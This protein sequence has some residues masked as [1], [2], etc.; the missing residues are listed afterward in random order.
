MQIIVAWFIFPPCDLA[1]ELTR[2][3]HS[4]CCVVVVQTSPFA[5]VCLDNECCVV[6]VVQQ[7]HLLSCARRNP[8]PPITLFE[9]KSTH[10]VF[11]SSFNCFCR[12]L[13]EFH[14]HIYP[15]SN[16]LI[17]ICPSSIL[18]HKKERRYQHLHSSLSINH[19]S[20]QFH[21]LWSLFCLTYYFC[22]LKSLRRH[23]KL[24][25]MMMAVSHLFNEICN[26][27]KLLSDDDLMHQKITIL[28][29]SRW[30]MVDGCKRKTRR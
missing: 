14:C 12:P 26:I 2:C 4:M 25:I 30:T 20:E 6:V 21:L 24:M 9:T 22:I 3:W 10:C 17:V 27:R 29:K 28:M 5:F 16:K 11:V 18:H 19:P 15:S 8:P 1:S 13:K 23:D 7:V